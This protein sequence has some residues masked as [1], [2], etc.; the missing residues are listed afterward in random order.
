MQKNLRRL[1]T[2]V[3]AQT[4]YNLE[5]LAAMAGYRSPGRVIDKLVRDHMVGMKHIEE[6]KPHGKR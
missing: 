5:K 1:T 3:T 4:L 2:R 6:E